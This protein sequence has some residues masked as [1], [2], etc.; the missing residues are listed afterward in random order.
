MLD[1]LHWQ[2][3][4]Q[5]HLLPPMAVRQRMLGR[6][7][8]LQQRPLLLQAWGGLALMMASMMALPAWLQSLP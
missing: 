4:M 6:A 1:H 7:L 5:G 8:Q 2:S 3:K